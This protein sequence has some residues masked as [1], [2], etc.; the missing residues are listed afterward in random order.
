M[1]KFT[2]QNEQFTDQN[3]PFTDQ[4]EPWLILVREFHGPKWAFTDQNEPSQEPK[5]QGEVWVNELPQ[6]IFEQPV[7]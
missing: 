1:S 5:P 4:N 6:L 7:G 3:E 2:D